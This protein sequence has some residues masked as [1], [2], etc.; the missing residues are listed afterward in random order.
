V[1]ACA[2]VCAKPA[3]RTKVPSKTD[4]PIFIFSLSPSWARPLPRR[5][6]RTLRGHSRKEKEEEFKCSEGFLVCA[7]GNVPPRIG[8]KTADNDI[9]ARRDCLTNDHLWRQIIVHPSD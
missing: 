5:A 2:A 1:T 6:S 3:L 7:Y 9:D 8:W 4:K